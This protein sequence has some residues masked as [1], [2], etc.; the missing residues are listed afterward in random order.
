MTSGANALKLEEEVNTESLNNSEQKENTQENG[1]SCD[2]TQPDYKAGNATNNKN[3][4]CMH[5]RAGATVKPAQYAT[6]GSAAQLQRH[7][8]RHRA[9][10]FCYSV[11]YVSVA[12]TAQR[13]SSSS[14]CSDKVPPDDQQH[15]IPRVN[16]VTGGICSVSTLPNLIGVFGTAAI[17]YRT[18]R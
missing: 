5:Y 6:V 11:M 16:S 9:S 7:V 15:R 13:S 4:S 3:V 10:S 12:S 18:L 2:A 8:L 17:V 14:G 1:V